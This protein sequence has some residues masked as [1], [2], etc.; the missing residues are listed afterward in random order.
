MTPPIGVVLVDDQPLVLAGLRMLLTGAQDIEVLGEAADGRS[1]LAVVDQLTPDVVVMDVRMPGMDGLEATRS[2][3]RRTG[4]QA[5]RP[6]I[7]VLTTFDDDATARA[8]MQAGASGFLL[9]HASGAELVHAI[10]RV[11]QDQAWLDPTVGARML[12]AWQ[13]EAEQE[14]QIETPLTKREQ[15][16][17]GMVAWGSAN[18]DIAR[19]LVLSLATVKTHVARILLKTGARDRAGLVALAYRSG[20]TRRQAARRQAARRQAAHQPGL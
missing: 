5:P 12:S 3:R 15:E 7:L 13:P 18:D 11:A 17:L 1:A 4:G 9:K 6:R 2:M 8:A 19:E 14:L 16:V 20:F 10:R